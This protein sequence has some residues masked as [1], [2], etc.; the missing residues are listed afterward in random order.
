MTPPPST[1]SRRQ[2]LTLSAATALAA[3]GCSAPQN[4]AASAE[5]SPSGGTRLT[6]IGTT[7]PSPSS[8]S[9]PRW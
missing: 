4:T 3:A 7:T 6:K 2:F 9:T 5:P 8:R 1:P